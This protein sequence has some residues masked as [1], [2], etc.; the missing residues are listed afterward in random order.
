MKKFY[1][2]IVIYLILFFTLYF[3]A[4]WFM[5]SDWDHEN[6]LLISLG[7]IMLG[8]T[9]VAVLWSNV[10]QNMYQIK[11]I[12][13]LLYTLVGV[14]WMFI[15]PAVALY[16][17]IHDSKVTETEYNSKFSTNVDSVFNTL[18]LGQHD[19]DFNTKDFNFGKCRVLI[20]N[21][22][23]TLC[24]YNY[25]MTKMLDSSLVAFNV[26]SADYFVIVSGYEALADGKLY[27]DGSYAYRHYTIVSFYDPW[28][29]LIKDEFILKGYEPPVRVHKTDS[30]CGE[31]I[32]NDS[33][34][35]FIAEKISG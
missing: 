2:T 31:H 21:F 7:L 9:A 15:F 34:V 6:A 29:K 17:S 23:D 11:Y 12:H 24:S 35:H 5:S 18:K 1:V 3:F 25:E 28:K 20:G 33:I 26:D 19:P 27:D 32:S 8:L 30:H 14:A 4:H 22:S 10:F 16:R 13:G